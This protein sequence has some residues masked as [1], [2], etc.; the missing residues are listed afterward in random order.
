MVISSVL[1]VV[2]RLLYGAC[3][4]AVVWLGG[5][6]YAMFVVICL[7]IQCNRQDRCKLWCRRLLSF[8]LLF[9]VLLLVLMLVLVLVVLVLL[10]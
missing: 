4:S 1:L 2:A 3:H 9:C 8:V 7:F 5:V 6:V 10:L